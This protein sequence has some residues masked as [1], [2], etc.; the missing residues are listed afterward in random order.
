[1]LLNNDNVESKQ[2]EA[3]NTPM[4]V[5][6]RQKRRFANRNEPSEC[7]YNKFFHR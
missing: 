6:N 4:Q 2:W 5:L 1:V 7:R 3:K